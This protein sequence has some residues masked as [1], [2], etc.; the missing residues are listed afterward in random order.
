[1]STVLVG[2]FAGLAL[3]LAAVGVYGIAAHVAAQ[4]RYELGVRVALGATAGQLV[5]LVISQALRPVLIGAVLGISTALATGRLLASFLFEIGPTDP[6]SFGAATVLLLS[7]AML[8]SYLPARRASQADPV[9]ALK[10][11]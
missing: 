1:M 6:A 7:V 5:T 9:A 11:E 10:S 3:L 8:A 2:G 4:R